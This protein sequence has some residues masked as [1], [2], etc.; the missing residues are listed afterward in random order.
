MVF[1]S[2]HLPA[3]W[4]LL[5]AFDIAVVAIAC[6]PNDEAAGRKVPQDS[7]V[8]QLEGPPDDDD[9]RFEAIDVFIDS[10]QVPL[11]AWQFELSAVSEGVEIVGIEG[12]EH[13][14]FAKPPY[15][16]PKAMNQKRAI[17]ASYSTLK[18]LPSGR[19]RIARI[20]VQLEGRGV[21]EYR[22]QLAVSADADGNKIPAKIEI[23][24]VKA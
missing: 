23:A 2:R 10:H 12:G 21:K 4:A 20:H 11:A 24:K 5:I 16:D 14:A 6:A 17:L 1:K 3:V 15:Y 7:V 18:E 9:I 13:A 8:T 22:T 19:S